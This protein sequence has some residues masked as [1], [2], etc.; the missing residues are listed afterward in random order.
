MYVYCCVYMLFHS[1]VSSVLY[2]LRYDLWLVLNKNEICIVY[3]EVSRAD[4]GQSGNRADARVIEC[5]VARLSGRSGERS[6]ERSGGRAGGLAAG[7]AEQRAGGRAGVRAVERAS[8]RAGSWASGRSGGRASG[9]A[10]G[11]S[12]LYARGWGGDI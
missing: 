7:R 12:D 2:T 1:V 9:R 4:V 5:T 6:G 8:G 11:L 3:M 10:C